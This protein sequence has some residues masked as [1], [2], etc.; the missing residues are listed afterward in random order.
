MTAVMG[1]FVPR[2]SLYR[3]LSEQSPSEPFN[4]SLRVCPPPPRTRGPV[5]CPRL[6]GG[7]SGRALGYICQSTAGAYR[8]CKVLAQTKETLGALCLPRY[9]FISAC[10]TISDLEPGRGWDR[11]AHNSPCPPGVPSLPRWPRHTDALQRKAKCF[12]RGDEKF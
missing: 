6:S 1:S 10:V 2:S 9:K 7:C 12:L 8:L 4:F 5:L 3:S 11:N